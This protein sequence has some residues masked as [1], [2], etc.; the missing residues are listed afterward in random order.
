MKQIPM[1]L[2]LGLALSLCGLL[3]KSKNSGS[4]GSSGSGTSSSSSSG[5]VEKAAPTAAQTAALAGGKSA[6]WDPQG[7]SWTVPANWTQSANDDASFIWQSPG[8]FDAG[9]LILNISPLPESF[10]AETSIQSM[11]DQ[12]KGEEK[13]GLLDE[14]KML[15]IDGVKGVETRQSNP[16]K[17]DDFRRLTW[18]AYRKYSG[19]LQL[20]TVILSSSGKGFPEHQDEMYGVLCS[21]KVVH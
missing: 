7:L 18:R 19:Q 12:A 6:K 10:P 2:V 15:E 11:Y 20:I 17:S 9:H 14:V 13:N 16:K 21:T 4:S 3:N 5:P 1:L 8:G